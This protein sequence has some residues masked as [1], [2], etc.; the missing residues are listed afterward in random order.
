MSRHEPD[1]LPAFIVE[2]L[3][4]TISYLQLSI[5][6]VRLQ[7][8]L[9]VLRKGKSVLPSGIDDPDAVHKG[10]T[11]EVACTWRHVGNVTLEVCR[12][13]GCLC[14]NGLTR[15]EIS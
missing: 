8:L 12:S 1:P 15:H 11:A 3:C 14:R 9:V 10:F 13:Y 2:F 5:S 6:T 7:Y 4:P